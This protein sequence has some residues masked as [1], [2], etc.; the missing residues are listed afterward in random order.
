M[1]RQDR[2]IAALLV[3]IVALV[4][5]S[6]LAAAAQGATL[7]A[8]VN[9]AEKVAQHV[10]PDAARACPNGFNVSFHRLDPGRQIPDGYRLGPDDNWAGL[11]PYADACGIYID[12]EYGEWFTDLC[13]VMIHE[14]GH[15]AD[16]ADDGA[17]NRYAA[18]NPD[19]PMHSLD[20]KSPMYP[21][22]QPMPQYCRHYGRPY[23][24]RVG[25]LR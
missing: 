3:L 9:R 17:D 25:A 4:A 11:Q 14:A 16:E 6:G 8:Q 1:T 24:T 19:D 20:P 2:F 21:T 18:T 23:L 5:L 10:Y 7:K 22:A 15:I 12:F 13:A